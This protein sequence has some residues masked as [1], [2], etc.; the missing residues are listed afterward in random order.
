MSRVVKIGLVLTTWNS[1]SGAQE[2]YIAILGLQVFE[3]IFF[4]FQFLTP[5]N[6]LQ[7]CTKLCNKR[8]LYTCAFFCRMW[9]C[10]R[11]ILYTWCHLKT[12][13][14][15]FW[16]HLFFFNACTCLLQKTQC[17]ISWHHAIFKTWLPQSWNCLQL[18]F[19]NNRPWTSKAWTRWVVF[20][21]LASQVLKRDIFSTHV[22]RSWQRYQL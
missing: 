5:P 10:A 7:P 2:W 9:G 11:M 20:Q 14:L 17:G 1:K 3:M 4:H 8:K 13:R 18:V 19:A 15:K 22:P 16:N 6:I 12:W 21:G